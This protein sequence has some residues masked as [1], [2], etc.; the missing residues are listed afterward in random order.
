MY[1]EHKR[2]H[3]GVRHTIDYL[4]NTVVI[5]V[6]R[7]CLG[8]PRWVQVSDEAISRTDSLIYVDQGGAGST[9]ELVYGPRIRRGPGVFSNASRVGAHMSRD[10]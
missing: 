3:C 9:E 2:V 1:G 5:K 10:Q 6:P 7:S 4:A 8:K